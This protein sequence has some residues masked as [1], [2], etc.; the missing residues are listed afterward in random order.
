MPAPFELLELRIPGIEFSAV[1]V[2]NLA[3]VELSL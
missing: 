2:G 1:V 3:R